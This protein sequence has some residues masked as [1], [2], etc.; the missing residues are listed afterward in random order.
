M[1]RLVY[2]NSEGITGVKILPTGGFQKLRVRIEVGNTIYGIT[3]KEFK[4]PFFVGNL[5]LLFL[6]LT[7]SSCHDEAIVESSSNF[8]VAPGDIVVS[9]GASDSVLLLDPD[10][11][12]KA[13]LYEMRNSI[14]SPFGLA[15]KKDTNEILVAVEGVDRVMAIS[16]YD[17]TQRIFIQE[18]NL[19]GV[20]KGLAQLD[21][22]NVAIYEGNSVELYSTLGLRITAGG[23][24]KALLTT[25]EQISPL[26]NGG[27]IGCASGTDRVRTYDAAGTQVLDKQSGIATTTDAMGCI[28]LANGNIAAVWSGTTDTVVIYDPTLTTS[29][30]S[31]S[32]T[33][34][35]ATPGGIAQAAN[36]NLLV[37]DTT[38]NHI[39]EIDQ[40]GNFIR[41]L[42]GDI[43]ATPRQI[44][45][46]P[47]FP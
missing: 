16:A 47:P 44:L 18:G 17:G 36:G 26:T 1:L 9:N 6:T 40:S 13:T 11:N 29:L 24:P 3:L 35:L 41:I 12:Y 21:N 39:F 34:E 30:A 33:T 46:I 25:P 27:F 32:N 22:G 42:A 38:L 31:F 45:V 19:N 8:L 20:M 37:L 7:L 2:L 5:L 10:G 14:D 28:E 4:L 43:L 23:W 15:W